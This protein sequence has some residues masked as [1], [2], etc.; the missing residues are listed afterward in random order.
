MPISAA[1][2]KTKACASSGNLAAFVSVPHDLDDRQG[3]EDDRN[4]HD[5]AANRPREEDRWITLRKK[6]RLGMAGSAIGPST[7]ASTAGATG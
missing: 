7:M 6:Q 2:Q 3:D 1:M 4:D 5:H